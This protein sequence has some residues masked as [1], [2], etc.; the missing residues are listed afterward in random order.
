MILKYVH[1]SDPNVEK[2]YD[3]IKAL[4]NNPFISMAQYEFDQMEM[5]R[6]DTDKN[7][8]SWNVSCCGDCETCDDYDCPLIENPDA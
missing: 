1:V 2:E 5:E 7:I 3:T 6:M 8:I 4:K